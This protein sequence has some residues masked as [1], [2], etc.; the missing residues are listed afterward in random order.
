MNNIENLYQWKI[1]AVRQIKLLAQKATRVA[2]HFNNNGFFSPLPKFR[3]KK[4]LTEKE[5]DAMI[6]LQLVKQNEL[7]ERMENKEYNELIHKINS[8]TMPVFDLKSGRLWSEYFK[9]FVS[10]KV[11]V[12]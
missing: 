10:N 12:E 3:Y 7:E 6:W 2:A 5:I 4:E 1:E 9:G 11:E 8:L